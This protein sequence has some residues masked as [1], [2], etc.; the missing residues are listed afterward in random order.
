MNEE[1][2]KH[3]RRDAWGPREVIALVIIVGSF[4]LAVI[5]MLADSGERATI[6][7]WVAALVAGIGVYY[8][9]NGKG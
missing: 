2:G 8:Y 7:A 1:P 6:P 4:G 5:H 3:R 9:R